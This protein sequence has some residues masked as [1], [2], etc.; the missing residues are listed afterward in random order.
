MISTPTRMD[1]H[2]EELSFII[3]SIYLKSLRGLYEETRIMIFEIMNIRYDQNIDYV[4]N[5][6]IPRALEE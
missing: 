6:W 2:V 1:A 4:E 5:I 3:D